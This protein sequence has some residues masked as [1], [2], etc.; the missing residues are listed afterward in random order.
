MSIIGAGLSPF[1]TSHAGLEPTITTT[2]KRKLFQDD[3]GNQQNCRLIDPVTQDYRMIDGKI[4]GGQGIQQLVYLAL[5]TVKGSCVISS[6]GNTYMNVK[7]IGS[8]FQQQ[9]TNEVNAS[10]ETLIK[11]NKIKLNNVIVEKQDTMVLITVQWT[12]LTTNLEYSNNI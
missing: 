8:N 7:V 3:Y 9:I 6:L 5:I 12:D 4:V 2:V 1:G 11:Q 10:L